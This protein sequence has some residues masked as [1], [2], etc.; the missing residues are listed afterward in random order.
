MSDSA[1]AE[2]YLTGKLLVAMPAIGDRR[3]D[4]SVIYVC[5]HTQ[6]G[7][8]GIVVNHPL[9]TPSFDDLARQ[10]SIRPMPPLRRV[11]LY[12]GGPV[13]TERG[14]VLHSSD[15]RSEES[16]VID[17]DIALTASLDALR[18]IAAGG[19]PRECVLALGYAGWGP[20]QLDNE[21]TANIWL[22]A[23]ND[24]TLLFGS[25]HGTKWARALAGLRI[26]PLQL[27]NVAGHA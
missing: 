21:L 18:T 16:L 25:D 26:D 3:F 27:S 24:Q 5:A 8:M 2:R 7:A 19:G 10:L 6:E 23:P 17:R 20:G 14:F 11:D 22:S 9:K 4:H 13:D 12:S 15:W 1:D